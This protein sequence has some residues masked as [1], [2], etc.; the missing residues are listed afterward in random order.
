MSVQTIHNSTRPDVSSIPEPSFSPN[1]VT[2]LEKRYLIKNDSGEPIETPTELVWRVASN[3]AEGELNFNADRARFEEVRQQYY[4]LMASCEFMPNSPTLMNAG[5]GRPQQLSACFVIPVEDAIDSIFDAV[6]HAAIIHKT[7]GGTGFAFS[8]LRPKNDRV[9]STKGI[10]SGPVSFMKVFNAATEAVKQGGTRRGANMGILRV[11]HPDILEFIECKADMT[12]VTNFNISVALTEKFMEAVLAESDYDLVNPKNGLVVGTL[13][14][15]EVFDKM[16]DNAWRNGDPGIVFIDRINRD[17]PTPQVGP[18]ESTNPCGEQPLLPY[19]AC[20]LGSLNLALMTRREVV[21]ETPGPVEL[22]ADGYT[23]RNPMHD[24]TCWVIDWE[25]LAARVELSIRFLDNVIEMSDFPLPAITNIVK[26]GNRKIGLGVMGFADLL[27]MLGIPYSSHEAVALGERMMRF[28]NEHAA[29][30]SE[31]LARERGAFGNHAQ[32]AFCDADHAW[33]NN[34]VPRRNATVTTIAPTGTIS[35]IAGCSSG[36]EPLF[37][38]CFHRKVLDGAT[39]VEAHP[40]FEEVA[41][42]R[43]FFSETLM[44]EVAMHGGVESI[45]DVPEDVR[46]VFVTSHDISPL[47]HLEHQAGFQRHCENAVSKTVN[48]N[49]SAT[50]DDVAEVYILAYKKGCKGTTIYRDG[51]RDIQVLNLGSGKKEESKVE[52]SAVVKSNGNGNGNGNSK[53]ANGNGNGGHSVSAAELTPT[54]LRLTVGG[55]SVGISAGGVAVGSAT[56]DPLVKRYR[57]EGDAASLAG[58]AAS[59]R[60]TLVADNGA[61]VPLHLTASSGMASSGVKLVIEGKATGPTISSGR[62]TPACPECGSNLEMAE[63]CM[64]CRSCGFSKCG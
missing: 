3:I 14:A 21:S 33:Y 24:G 26:H 13:N 60:L 40:F 12:S 28:I 63:G 31:E 20:N 5:K 53:A 57:V 52:A 58:L 42:A 23:S 37:A 17:N 32:S 16:V 30:A 64:T 7:G 29:R 25:K 48:F 55:A 43:G 41:R 38:L 61:H 56:N 1:A 22:T 15:R 45:A 27:Y 54:G 6:K 11:D 46:Q 8:R 2:V 39:L 44:Q 35:I 34:G 19:E 4:E 10:S 18:M 47:W 49:N 50:R 62:S 51:S 9:R 36:I 59:G